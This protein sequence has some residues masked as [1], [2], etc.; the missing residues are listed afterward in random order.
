MAYDESFGVSGK[1]M[2]LV[3]MWKCTDTVSNTSCFTNNKNE[4]NKK[5]ECYSLRQLVNT[6]DLKPLLRELEKIE[7]MRNKVIIQIYQYLYGNDFVNY[8]K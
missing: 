3:K 5:G 7:S 1:L 2:M 8:I 4:M 6:K